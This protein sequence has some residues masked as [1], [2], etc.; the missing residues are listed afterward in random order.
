MRDVQDLIDSPELRTTLDRVRDRAAT[1]RREIRAEL[2]KPDWTVV[3]LEII[4]PLVEVRNR[5]AEDLARRDNKEALVPIDREPVPTRYQDS[6]RKYF[7][8]LGK[9]REGSQ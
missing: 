9:D 3:E 6:V 2:K 4:K 7:E 5:V 8:E 1:L